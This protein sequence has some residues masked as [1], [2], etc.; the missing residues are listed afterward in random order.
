MAEEEKKDAIENEA[1][2]DDELDEEQL[3][4]ASGGLRLSSS[5]LKISNDP[6]LLKGKISTDEVQGADDDLS[7]LGI[8]NTSQV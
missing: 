4:E 8:T 3:D 7:K 2:T 5:Q 6:S 1:Q